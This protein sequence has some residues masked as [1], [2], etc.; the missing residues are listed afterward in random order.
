MISVNGKETAG[1]AGLSITDFLRARDYD[2]R[3]V[4]VGLNDA[5]IPKSAYD[6]IV[7]RDGDRVEIVNFVS[8]G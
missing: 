4:A 1:A 2:A 8:G 7:L 6:G 3:R 5:I